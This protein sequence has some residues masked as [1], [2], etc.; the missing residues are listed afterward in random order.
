M[1]GV[2]VKKQ[3]NDFSQEISGRE[4]KV[5]WEASDS[6]NAGMSKEYTCGMGSP[7]WMDRESGDWNRGVYHAWL[8][9]CTR[10]QSE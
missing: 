10:W 1:S 8:E 3:K 5:D 4:M 6:G 9:Q 2:A 7:A